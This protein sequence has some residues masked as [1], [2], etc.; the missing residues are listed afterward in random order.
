M[1]CAQADSLAPQTWMSPRVS[2]HNAG[3]Q[4]KLLLGISTLSTYMG[5]KK[6]FSAG[7][8]RLVPLACS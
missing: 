1:D 8:R 2:R 4:Y 5:V 6:W 3:E 7:I